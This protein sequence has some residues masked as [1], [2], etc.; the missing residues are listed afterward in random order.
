MREG[1]GLRTVCVVEGAGEGAGGAG[2][3]L[4]E[5]GE[6]EGL[7]GLDEFEGEPGVF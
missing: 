2:G 6:R 7:D 3:V 4:E 1:V 5:F